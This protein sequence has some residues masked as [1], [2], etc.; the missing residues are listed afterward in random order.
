[1]VS[2]K[3]AILEFEYY[4]NINENH[5]TKRIKY[6]ETRIGSNKQIKLMEQK[7]IKITLKIEMVY[8]A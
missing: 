4:Y 5:E 7:R 6:H 2:G 8:R 1:M 3:P